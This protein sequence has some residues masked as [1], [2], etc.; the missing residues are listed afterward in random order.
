MSAR[1]GIAE[2]RSVIDLGTV[3]A[4]AFCAPAGPLSSRQPTISPN[5]MM[6]TANA[7]GTLFFWMLCLERVDRIR[8]A[9]DVIGAM[10]VES[11]PVRS[12]F[13]GIESDRSTTGTEGEER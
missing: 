1:S 2:S 7:S 5:S 12:R 3:G 4:L 10:L 6:A 9:P 13:G 8:A 11:S